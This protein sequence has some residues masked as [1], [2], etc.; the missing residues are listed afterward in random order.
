MK[1]TIHRQ[2]QKG[3]CGQ[4]KGKV[5]T[6][7]DLDV[8]VHTLSS[9]YVKNVKSLTRK[10]EVCQITGEREREREWLRRALIG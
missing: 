8:M 10:G 4:M 1:L 7:Q 2:S 3:V 9:D 5:P 6:Q